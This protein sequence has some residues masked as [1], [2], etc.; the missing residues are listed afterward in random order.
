MPEESKYD[1]KAYSKE[2]AAVVQDKINEFLKELGA[3]I[4][5]SNTVQVFKRVPKEE[6]GVP[7]PAEFLPETNARGA[8]DPA[9]SEPAA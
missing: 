8:A 9:S 2:E 5:V 6:V 1:L 7:T 3:E 4:V